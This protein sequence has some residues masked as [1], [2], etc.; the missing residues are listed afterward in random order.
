MKQ[1]STIK[2]IT[3]WLVIIAIIF[4]PYV[5]NGI[6]LTN[7]DFESNYR[8]EVVHLA[9]LVIPPLSFITVWFSTDE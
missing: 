3:A 8:C 4:G 5:Y 7:C 6:K 9:G 2:E 1:K